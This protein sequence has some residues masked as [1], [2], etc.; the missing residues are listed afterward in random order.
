MTTIERIR[1]TVSGRV[2]GV[3]FRAWTVARAESLGV[4]GFV[5]N[6]DDGAVVGEVQGEVPAVAEF[7]RQL[8]R[9]PPLAQVAAVATAGIAVAIGSRFLVRRDL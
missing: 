1:F 3:G 7:V 5:G 8:Q 9:G 6:R 2:Q 4:V